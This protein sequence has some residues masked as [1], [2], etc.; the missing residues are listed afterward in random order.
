MT[1]LYWLTMAAL[2]ALSALVWLGAWWCERRDIRG[3]VRCACP[4]SCAP[5]REGQTD[6]GRAHE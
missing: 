5:T 1:T 2:C 4:A 3:G 6:K